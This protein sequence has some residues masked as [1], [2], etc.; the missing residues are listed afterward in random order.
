M[1][2]SISG[3]SV[4]K[5]MNR[6]LLNMPADFGLEIFYEYGSADLWN[7]LLGELSA[8]GM[9]GFSIHAPF[10]FADITADCDETALFDALRRPFDLYHR[11]GGEFYVL[12]TYGPSACSGDEAFR[13]DC[14]AR[15]E[16]RLGKFNDICRSEGVVLGAENLCDGTPPLFTGEQFLRL[17]T[18]LP[19]L[20][21]VLDIGHA[22]V[23]GMDIARLQRELG[24]RIRAYHLHNNTGRADTHDR[25]REGVMDWS[26]FAEN[27]LRY[28][29][30]AV[31]VLEYLKYQD[32]SVYEEDRAYL[33]ALL[34]NAGRSHG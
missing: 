17:F 29:P 9:D 15:A 27:C 28:T 16:E 25:L 1:R 5:L 14:R 23:A 12:H 6:K 33:S 13:A 21:C 22:L 2:F 20:H 4:Y 34:S 24:G 8:R 32:M 11:Y 30:D 19:D 26:A 31:G 7:S 18:D 3:C 10:A